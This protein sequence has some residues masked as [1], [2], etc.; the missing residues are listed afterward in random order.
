MF[1]GVNVGVT[2]GVV[3]IVGVGVVLAPGVGVKLLV[4]VGVRV[5]LQVF[6]EEHSKTREST[7][8]TDPELLFVNEYVIIAKS[9]IKC[10]VTRIT[11]FS[12]GAEATKE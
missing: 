12:V 6:L 10:L 9:T 4:G 1:V 11:R 8:S 3:V 2:V 7:D 5:S